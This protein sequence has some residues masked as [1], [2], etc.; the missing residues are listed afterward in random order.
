M[1]RRSIKVQRDSQTFGLI[2]IQG[3]QSIEVVPGR[4]EYSIEFMKRV[5][6][7]S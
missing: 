4:R 6:F 7:I 1:Y 3:L 5:I 2:N